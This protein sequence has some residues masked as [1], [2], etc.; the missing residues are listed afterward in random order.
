M[1]GAAFKK[2]ARGYRETLMEVVARPMRFVKHQMEASKI[3]PC[4]AADLIQNVGNDATAED[5]FVV[6]W[7]A[8]SLYTGGSDTVSSPLNSSE[9]RKLD[10]HS[11]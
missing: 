2:M 4:F 10:T 11:G 5:E 3:E 1:P 6:N 8:A 7:T 9:Y